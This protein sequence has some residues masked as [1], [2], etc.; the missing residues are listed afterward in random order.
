MSLIEE[1]I[2]LTKITN[3]SKDSV[4]LHSL[5]IHLHQLLIV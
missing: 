4:K 2:S 1:I 3:K 5:K